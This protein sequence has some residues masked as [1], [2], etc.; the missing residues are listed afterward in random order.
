MQL[1]R[2]K[3]FT[4]AG[5]SAAGT[6]MMSPLQALYAKNAN[7]ESV[8]GGGYGPLVPDPNGLLDL[9]RRFKYEAFSRTGEIMSDGSP[10]P[11]GHDGMAA[12]PG[13]G[14]T[15]IL[16]RNHELSPNSS[17]QVVGPNP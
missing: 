17:T 11:G 13:P 10:V 15:V 8:F 9:P 4:L 16:V 14:N 2:R 3:F 5:A 1:S 7:G 12:F 6:L